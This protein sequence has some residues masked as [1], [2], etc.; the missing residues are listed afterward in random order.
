[1]KAVGVFV[2]L[3]ALSVR[4][5][6]AG[7]RTELWTLKKSTSIFVRWGSDTLTWKQDRLRGGGRTPIPQIKMYEFITPGGPLRK[8]YLLQELGVADVGAMPASDW[9]QLEPWL[10]GHGVHTL[11]WRRRDRRF[12]EFDRLD[13][14]LPPWIQNVWWIS[15][16]GMPDKNQWR[17]KI[18]RRFWTTG[19]RFLSHRKHR[20]QARR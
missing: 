7:T 3:L 20:N 4:V 13:R 14:R 9:P 16:P 6:E 10:K 2:L 8:V 15:K 11:I 18:T 1:L 17:R 12:R 19:P 5:F